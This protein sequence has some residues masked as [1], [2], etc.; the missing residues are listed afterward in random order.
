MHPGED[1][2]VRVVLRHQLSFLGLIYRYF[3]WLFWLAVAAWATLVI[4]LL[5]QSAEIP[6]VLAH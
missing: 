2:Q 5:I 4:L 6:A 3:A 1:N